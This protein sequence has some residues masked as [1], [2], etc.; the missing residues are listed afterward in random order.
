MSRLPITARVKRIANA[1]LDTVTIIIVGV[2]MTC[3]LAA[4]ALFGED[5]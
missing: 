2:L 1:L 5:E 4:Q 3:A